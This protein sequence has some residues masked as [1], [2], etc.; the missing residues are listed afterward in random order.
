MWWF[1]YGIGNES[2]QFYP[3]LCIQVIDNKIKP[4]S[5]ASQQQISVLD[6]IYHP[7]KR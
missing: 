6:G 2:K 7:N 3:Q 5:I 4:P 1:D